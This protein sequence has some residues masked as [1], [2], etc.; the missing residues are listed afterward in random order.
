MTAALALGT[1][2]GAGAQAAPQLESFTINAPLVSFLHTVV[3]GETFTVTLRLDR[4]APAG[5]TRVRVSKLRDS[6]PIYTLPK[7]AV[8]P[9][10]G[11]SR[12]FTVETLPIAPGDI[13]P[14]NQQ[15]AG[16]IVSVENPDVLFGSVFVVPRPRDDPRGDP[17]TYEAEN[18]TLSGARVVSDAGPYS[19]ASNEAF[20]VYTSRTGS[21]TFDVQARGGTN[22]VIFRY[23]YTGFE[24]RQMR[25]TVNGSGQLVTFPPTPGESWYQLT[26]IQAP[27]QTGSNTIRVAAVRRSA[28]VNLDFLQVAL[29]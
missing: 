20:V 7:E 9:Q 24:A 15:L 14:S 10:G 25:V 5:G 12:T 29:P 6:G 26:A 16:S 8:I 27:L 11:R 3:G 18:A 13:T 1:A 19:L 28:P 23:A 4:A 2:P 21:A 22:L 17:V